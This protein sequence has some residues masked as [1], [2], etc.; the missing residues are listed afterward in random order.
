MHSVSLMTGV[1]KGLGLTP[2]HLTLGA[3]FEYGTGTYDTHNAFSTAASV[4]GE[5]D[6]YHLGGGVLGRM[7]FVAT[8]PG[9]LYTEASLRAGGVHNEYDS[10]DLRDTSG[11]KAKYD[12]SSAYYGVHLGV[13][14]VWK[15]TEAAALDIYGKYFWTRQEGDSVRLSTGDPVKFKDVDSNRLRL[16]GRFAYVLNEHVS[17]YVGV[18]WE[19]E[20][21]GR[22]RATAYGDAIESPD[23]SGNT[24]IGEI[25]LSL[26]PSATLPLSFDFGVQGYTGQRKGVTGSLQVKFEF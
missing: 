16:G 19:H 1:S 23:L 8:G 9:H 18:A 14:Y 2:G 17:P 3:F 11:R 4:D 7:D 15:L 12:S 22:A 6:I 13:G 10:A 24:G 25:G 20:F 5:G 26:K 21:D